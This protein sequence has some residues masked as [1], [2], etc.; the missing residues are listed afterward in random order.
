MKK[1][2]YKCRECGETFSDIWAGLT[3]A[4]GE[5]PAGALCQ[6]CTAKR[7]RHAQGMSKDEMNNIEIDAARMGFR[8]GGINWNR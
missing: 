4:S 6:V 1:D 2:E 7:L 3:R 8:S 5:D